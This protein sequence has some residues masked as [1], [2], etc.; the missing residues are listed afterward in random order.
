MPSAPPAK[1]I[2]V[3]GSRLCM[4]RPA[5]LA[6]DL[7]DPLGHARSTAIARKT[8]ASNARNTFAYPGTGLAETRS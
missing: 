8:W 7:H 1:R 6:G 4:D 2:P 3:R 5:G